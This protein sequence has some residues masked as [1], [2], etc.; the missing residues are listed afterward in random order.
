MCSF[1]RIKKSGTAVLVIST[2]TVDEGFD[3]V[4]GAFVE[5]EVFRQNVYYV[6]QGVRNINIAE[7][8]EYTRLRTVD[9]LGFS[10]ITYSSSKIVL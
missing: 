6:F 4:D 8:Y 1:V 9:I 7:K 3:G 5:D 10:N 2:K